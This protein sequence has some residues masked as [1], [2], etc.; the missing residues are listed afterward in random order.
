MYFLTMRLESSTV[1]GHGG[2][3]CCGGD[4]A[5]GFGEV[6]WF[7]AEQEIEGTENT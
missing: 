2:G 5:V 7:A 6:Q 4:V 1:V 3:C